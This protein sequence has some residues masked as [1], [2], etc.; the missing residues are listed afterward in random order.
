MTVRKRFTPE[1]I[2]LFQ[3][4]VARGARPSDVARRHGFSRGNFVRWF[5]RY[6]RPHI[7]YEPTP[8][9][10]RLAGEWRKERTI[11]AAWQAFRAFCEDPRWA[12]DADLPFSDRAIRAGAFE[13]LVLRALPDAK[14]VVVCEKMAVCDLLNRWASS[15]QPSVAHT[16][17]ASVAWMTPLPS[18]WACRTLRAHAADVR[19][20]LVFLGDLD[21]QALHAFAVLRAGGRDAWLKGC[22]ERLPVEWIGLDARWL[23]FASRNAR[24]PGLPLRSLITLGW[25][26]REYWELMKR[27]TPDVRRLF[28]SQGS[29]LLD[30]GT[31]IEVDGL[32]HEG[33]RFTNELLRRL[34]SVAR[35][36]EPRSVHPHRKNTGRMP[37]ANPRSLRPWRS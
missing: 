18:A 15:K 20:P 27:T 26:D 19:A 4:E 37:R 7:R 24:K 9:E 31:K 34:E 12:F 2:S 36:G 8:G 11:A 6:G 14:V 1:E 35:R 23:K 32:F 30:G 3:L 22:T 5:R 33:D 17:R 25:L 16:V 13:H 21:P 28:G 10:V 29:A